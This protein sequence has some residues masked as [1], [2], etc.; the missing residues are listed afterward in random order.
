MRKTTFALGLGIA[1]SLGAADLSAQQQRPAR[2]DSAKAG[3][4]AGG[5]VGPRGTR[6]AMARG[7]QGHGMLLRDITLT[8][9]QKAQLQAHRTQQ[10][11]ARRAAAGANRQAME[12]AR[13][14]RQSGDTAALRAFR[15]GQQARMTAARDAEIAA[16]R[17]I[18]TAE[19]R[20]QFDKNVATMKERTARMTERRGGGGKRAGR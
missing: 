6:G 9:A 19:Q 15:A 11:E 18:L 3:A 17:N 13:A 2:P 1:L 4:R 14:A 12:Q 10:Q 20:V 8:D 5:Q 7:P 16:I